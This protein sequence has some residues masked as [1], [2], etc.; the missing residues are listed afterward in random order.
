MNYKFLIIAIYSL[1]I[2]L[3]SSSPTFSEAL[4]KTFDD[5][6][7]ENDPFFRPVSPSSTLRNIGTEAL[8]LEN[9]MLKSQLDA[10]NQLLSKYMRPDSLIV[11]EQKREILEYRS[12]AGAAIKSIT[13]ALSMYLPSLGFS[14]DMITKKQATINDIHRSSSIIGSAINTQKSLAESQSIKIAAQAIRIKSLETDLA[15][16]A[17]ELDTNRILT[18]V[19]TRKHESLSAKVKNYEKRVKRTKKL[20]TDN[21]KLKQE[22]AQL[23]FHTKA[24]RDQAKKHQH[25]SDK[26]T[27]RP[28][29]RSK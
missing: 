13:G 26:K 28:T 1:P 11:Q 14:N 19:L 18:D 9:E 23:E 22:I 5:D 29:K 4:A 24:Y 21:K 10:S 6:S 7:F 27:K 8:C 2:N 12:V 15:T 3:V 16:K 20:E 25:T 17:V